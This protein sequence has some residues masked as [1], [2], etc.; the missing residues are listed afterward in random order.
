M[1]GP[2]DSSC[3]PLPLN[4]CIPGNQNLLIKMAATFLCNEG[5]SCCICCW[6][7]ITAF[8]K[9]GKSMFLKCSFARL[10]I[11]RNMFSASSKRS[12]T[13]AILECRYGRRMNSV[14]KPWRVARSLCSYRNFALDGIFLRTNCTEAILCIS[15]GPLKQYQINSKKK[16]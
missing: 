10:G 7:Q 4:M 8:S 5:I 13:S 15:H 12:Q 3:C 16:K 9:L 6:I 14:S 1:P 2:G 11:L